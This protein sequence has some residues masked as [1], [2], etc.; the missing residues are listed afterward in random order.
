MPDVGHFSFVFGGKILIN[1]SFKGSFGWLVA[2]G[3]VHSSKQRFLWL[4]VGGKREE[5]MQLFLLSA[6]HHVVHIAVANACGPVSPATHPHPPKQPRTSHR[7][8]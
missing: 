8:S 7:T 5:Y 6:L 4:T 1:S 3:G 2:V